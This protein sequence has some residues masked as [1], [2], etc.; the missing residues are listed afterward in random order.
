[1]NPNRKIPKALPFM[2]LFFGALCVY[3][4]MPGSPGAPPW[5]VELQGPVMGTT[6]S[7]KV[8]GRDMSPADKVPIKKSVTQAMASVNTAMSTY[9]KTSELSLFNASESTLPQKMSAPT[10]QVLQLA[11]EISKLTQGRFDVTVG[12]LVNAWGFGPEGPQ[13]MVSEEELAL[14][15]SYVGYQKL[16]LHL[17]SQSL[18]KAHP[19]TYVDLSAIAKGFAVDQVA[20]SIEA[21][22]HSSYMIEIGGEVFAKGQNAKDAPWRIGIETPSAHAPGIFQVV[23]L[24]GEAL[25]TSG[26]YRNFYE[27]DGL[28]FSHTIDP[29]TGRP[30]KHNLAS[31]SVVADSCA[32]ADALATALNVLG[33]IKGPELAEQE[34]ISALFIIRDTEGKLVEK[35]SSTFSNRTKRAKY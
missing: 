18:S 17:E 12:P 2:I 29:Q 5:S 6:Y 15:L 20:A 26:D 4:L 3:R 8:V 27:K 21:L 1:M 32:K 16:T 13:N 23:K 31:V 14:L 11:Q 24:S 25:A 19:K 34:Q 30:I 10:L 22:G 33:P 28:R 9:L 35:P 7:I